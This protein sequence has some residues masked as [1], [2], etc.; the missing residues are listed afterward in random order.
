ML[1]CKDKVVMLGEKELES[2]IGE[3]SNKHKVKL[4]EFWNGCINY[5]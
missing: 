5:Y 4:M 3:L 1:M 2:V